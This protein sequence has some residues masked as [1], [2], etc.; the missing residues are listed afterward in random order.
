VEQLLRV[1]APARVQELVELVEVANAAARA[2]RRDG[3]VTAE[4]APDVDDEMDGDARSPEPADVGG[5]AR[6][7]SAAS[8]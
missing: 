4:V 2:A 1:D 5:G 6:A 7:A 3:E 8:A